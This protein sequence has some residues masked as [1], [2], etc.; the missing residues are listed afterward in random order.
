M[1]LNSAG[2]ETKIA[3][4]VGN[5]GILRRLVMQ[6]KEQKGKALGRAYPQETPPLRS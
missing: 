5:K 4:F 2:S 3:D 6:R 1:T